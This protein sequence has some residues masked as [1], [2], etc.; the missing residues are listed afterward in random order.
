MDTELSHPE[1]ADMRKRNTTDTSQIDGVRS[2][3]FSGKRR[4]ECGLLVLAL[5][6]GGLD[7]FVVPSAI[8]RM[9]ARMDLSLDLGGVLYGKKARFIGFGLRGR[10]DLTLYDSGRVTNA[11]R[12]S[13]GYNYM[14]WGRDR[15]DIGSTGINEVSS[16]RDFEISDSFIIKKLGFTLGYRYI[17]GYN[18]SDY[19]WWS[20]YTS[21]I[22]WDGRYADYYWF[23]EHKLK[24]RGVMYGLLYRHRHKYRSIWDGK[25]KTMF[26]EFELYYWPVDLEVSRINFVLCR[27]HLLP[28]RRGFFVYFR[29]GVCDVRGMFELAMGGGYRI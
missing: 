20:D 15:N 13:F 8:A 17:E 18:K 2:M 22:A 7:L 4:L 16:I 19:D 6:L 25:E 28:E 24:L 29:G 26:W 11:A 14:D 9:S 1:L 27:A 23:E 12:L 21:D 10:L 5:C 3:R